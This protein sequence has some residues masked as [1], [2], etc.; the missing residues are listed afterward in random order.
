MPI[1]YDGMDNLSGGSLE[2]YYPESYKSLYP[3][4]Q[5]AVDQFL[6]MNPGAV[7]DDDALEDMVDSILQKSS[8]NI[9]PFSEDEFEAVSVFQPFGMGR[10]FP[11]RRRGNDI[12]DLI[13]ILLLREFLDR[14]HHRP[15]PPHNR[16]MPPH[17][18]PRQ[19]MPFQ[20]Y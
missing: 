14:S 11:G 6:Q 7:I 1:D 10:R 5:D 2:T 3:L 20:D 12:N 4:I 9:D 8:Q 16:P 17:N 19:Y 18:R 15:R 13:R